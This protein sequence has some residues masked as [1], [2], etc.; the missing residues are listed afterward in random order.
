MKLDSVVVDQESGERLPN[1]TIRI[2]NN[3]GSVVTGGVYADSNG[4]FSI[5]V[6][7]SGFILVSYT[8]YRPAVFPVSLVLQTQAAALEIADSQNLDE[9]VVTAKKN[10][11]GI[12]LVCALLTASYFFK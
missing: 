4:A 6:P 8:G 3:D 7:E 1:A 5:D 11:N 10:S 9:V 2:S 12:I